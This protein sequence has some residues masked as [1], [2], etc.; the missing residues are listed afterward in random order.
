M[1]IPKMQVFPF[2]EF[3]GCLPDRILAEKVFEENLKN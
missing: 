1:G 2:S 3:K